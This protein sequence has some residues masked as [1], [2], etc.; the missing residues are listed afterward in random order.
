[1][2]QVIPEAE[3][4]RKEIILR[5]LDLPQSVTLTKKSLLR[6]CSLSLG[7][8]SPKESRD[9]AIIIFDSLFSL[10]FKKKE[11]PTTLD[12]QA[13]IKKKYSF[14]VSEK[15]IRYHLNRLVDLGIIQRKKNRYSINPNPYSEKRGSLSASFDAWVRAPFDQELEKISAALEKLQRIYEK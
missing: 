4:I 11:K 7:L 10:L 12:V 15:L 1:M 8:I 5:Q 13:S 3:Y 2:A 6:W 9:K 14:V